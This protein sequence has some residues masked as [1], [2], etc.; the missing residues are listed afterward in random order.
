[1]NIKLAVSNQ[2][3]LRNPMR[4]RE[5]IKIVKTGSENLL[6]YES[7]HNSSA[8]ICFLMFETLA[9]N[10]IAIIAYCKLLRNENRNNGSRCVQTVSRALFYAKLKKNYYAL[11]NPTPTIF[12]FFFV[13][14]VYR[15]IKSVISS[16][17]ME[18]NKNVFMKRKLN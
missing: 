15:T 9:K 4:S 16:Q 12:N 6:A 3:K 5:P 1:M 13:R 2:P 10:L 14:F 17:L 11:T 18:E 8:N 7:A